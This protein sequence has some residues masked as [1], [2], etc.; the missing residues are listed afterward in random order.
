[1]SR[2]LEI[3]CDRCNERIHHMRANEIDED[4][5]YGRHEHFDLCDTCHVQFGRWVKNGYEFEIVHKDK[6]RDLRKAAQGG[7][8]K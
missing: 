4:T 8:D 5:S 7:T 1:M 2:N 6:L 3:R